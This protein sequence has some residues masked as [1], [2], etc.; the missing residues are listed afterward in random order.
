MTQ[1]I[2]ALLVYSRLNTKGAEFETADLNV[3]IDQLQSL[4]IAAIIEDTNA[5]LIVPQKLPSVVADVAML[6]QLIQNLVINGIKY[7]AE[8]VVPEIV[9]TACDVDED[10]VK[11]LISDNGIG[12]KEEL[13]ETI[14][15]MFKRA[16]S[17]QKYEGT[18]IGLAVCRKIVEKHG[19]TIG[20]DSAE[21]QG[22]VFWFTIN[23]AKEAVLV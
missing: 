14:F 17:R 15:K 3:I 23:K 13:H 20:V 22:S 10:T 12:I 6:R 1:M 9:I 19:G 5:R 8:G 16:H 4:E 11:I 2:E 18:G 21:G 7:R